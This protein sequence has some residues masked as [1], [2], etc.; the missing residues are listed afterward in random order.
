MNTPPMFIATP[1]KPVGRPKRKTC[2]MICQSG[3]QLVSLVKLTTR[4]PENI[5]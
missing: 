1:W 3:R 4:E 2:A 5:W